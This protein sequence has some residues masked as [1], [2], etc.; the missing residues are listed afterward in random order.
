MFLVLESPLEKCENSRTYDC[1][2]LT[3]QNGYCNYYQA[4]MERHCPVS[5]NLCGM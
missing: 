3:S 5:C 4:E 1:A 2:K